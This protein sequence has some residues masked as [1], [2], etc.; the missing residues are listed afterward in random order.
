MEII[1]SIIVV[2]VLIWALSP[3]KNFKRRAKRKKSPKN[4]TKHQRNINHANAI[5]QWLRSK[6]P[7]AELPTVIATLRK[8]D[9][10]VFEELLLA[11]CQEQGWQIERNLKYSGDGGVDGRVWIADSLYLIQA[12]R[13]ADY[14]NSQHIQQFQQIIQQRSA[15]GGFFIHTGKTGD[16]SKQM[17]N[18]CPQVI[19]VSGQRLVDFVLGK[20]IKITSTSLL[21]QDI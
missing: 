14:I 10:Y 18:D 3:N 5:R 13:Y 17:I 2:V 12:K 9:P 8:I 4:Q 19:L 16:K 6:N 1:V 11:C 21:S 20:P 7:E 15:S